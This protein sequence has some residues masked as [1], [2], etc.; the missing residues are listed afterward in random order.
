MT[1]NKCGQALG[2]K[3]AYCF[4]CGKV[5]HVVKE[6]AKGKIFIRLDKILPTGIF[7]TLL[8]VLLLFIVLFVLDMHI[9]CGL[10]LAMIVSGICILAMNKKAI[11]FA[12]LN[13]VNASA[14]ASR[15]C[16]YCFSQ[17]NER[18][19]YCTLCGSKNKPLT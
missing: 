2:P 5:S 13:A 8:G 18:G 15:K 17:L 7:I 4:N 3:D 12:R 14:Y 6:A 11:R 10:P 16:R 19:L 1:C 9:L